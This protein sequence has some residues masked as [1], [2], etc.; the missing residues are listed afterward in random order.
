MRVIDREQI[1]ALLAG[2]TTAPRRRVHFNLHA[3]PAEPINRLVI[4]LEPD[5]YIRPHRHTDRFELFVLIAGRC[6]L[7]TF[8]GDGGVTRRVEMGDGGPR[9]AEFPPGV[10][11]SLVALEA[12]TVVLEV[13]PGPYVPTAGPDFAAWA[14]PEG[15]DR[16]AACREWMRQACVASGMARLGQ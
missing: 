12:G 4:A 11:H 10:W 7:L 2:A 14:P 6:A 13:K 9:I 15:D 16:A 5:A 8:D 1:D 3:D